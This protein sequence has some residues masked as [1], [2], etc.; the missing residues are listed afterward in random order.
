VV[1]SGGK[2]SIEN[3]KSDFDMIQRTE[4]WQKF[5]VALAK[6]ADN[7]KSRAI[8]EVDET[9]IRKLQGQYEMIKRVAAIPQMIANGT[10]LPSAPARG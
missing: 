2:L 3:L 9:R 10:Y 6:E 7:T 4:F 1:C 5:M 8:T